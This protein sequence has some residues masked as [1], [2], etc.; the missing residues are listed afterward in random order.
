MLQHYVVL[1]ESGVSSFQKGH[2][3]MLGMAPKQEYCILPT[4]NPWQFHT[5]PVNAIGFLNA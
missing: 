4:K 3:V 1:P 2:Y 5:H